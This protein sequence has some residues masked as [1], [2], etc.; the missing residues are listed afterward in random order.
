MALLSP[1]QAPPPAGAAPPAPDPGMQ[2]APP[3]GGGMMQ[4]AMPGG[5]EIDEQ[6]VEM[7]LDTAY[8]VIYGGDTKDGEMSAPVLGMLRSG[9]RGGQAA[10]PVNALSETAGAVGAKAMQDLHGGGQK[11]DGAAGFAGLM[12][13]VGELATL[14]ADEGVYDYTQD[15]IDEAAISAGQTFYEGTKDTGA[16]PQEEMQRDVV[17]MSDASESGEL[18]TVLGEMMAADQQQRAMG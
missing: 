7:F 16:F 5:D 1:G 13:L 9:P 18:D 14:A 17:E 15:E 12:E 8:E 10:S 11:I 2:Q 6:Q 3:Q 4:N